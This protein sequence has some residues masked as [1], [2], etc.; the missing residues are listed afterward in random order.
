MLIGPL[1]MSAS[2][3]SVAVELHLLAPGRDVDHPGGPPLALLDLAPDVPHRP[4]GSSHR[5][6]PLPLLLYPVDLAPLLLVLLLR[7]AAAAL[8][9]LHPP[10]GLLLLACAD[11]GLGKVAL[12][13]AFP[14]VPA[15]CPALVALLVLLVGAAGAPLLGAP[16]PPSNC[17]CTC[18]SV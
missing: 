7:A 6:W 8:L 12:L 3:T 4:L 15:L 5:P 1:S 10:C 18:R 2:A 11:L 16:P 14:A 9:L 13:A 17:R